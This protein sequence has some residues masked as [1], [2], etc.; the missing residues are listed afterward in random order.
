MMVA[1]KYWQSSVLLVVVVQLVLLIHRNHNLAFQTTVQGRKTA[2]EISALLN[3]V[4]LDG[5]KEL[6]RMVPWVT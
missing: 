5:E 1:M 6:V 3:H 2:L 4:T